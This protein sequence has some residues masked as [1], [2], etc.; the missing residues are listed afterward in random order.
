MI[1][2]IYYH[3]CTCDVCKSVKHKN[4]S[5]EI[6]IIGWHFVRLDKTGKKLE[7]CDECFKHLKG[8]VDSAIKNDGFVDTAKGITSL[9]IEHGQNDMKFKLGEMIK[10]SPSEVGDIINGEMTNV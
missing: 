2:E 3:E 6:E 4:P 8:Y 10:Y 5:Q 1:K 7:L 9:L